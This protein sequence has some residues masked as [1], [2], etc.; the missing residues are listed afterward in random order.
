MENDLCFSNLTTMTAVVDQNISLGSKTQRSIWTRTGKNRKEIP[1]IDSNLVRTNLVEMKNNDELKLKVQECLQTC[2]TTIEYQHFM[3]ETVECL[4]KRTILNGLLDLISLRVDVFDELYE[5]MFELVKVNIIRHILP[6]DHQIVMEVK[7]LTNLNCEGF[8][9][10]SNNELNKPAPIYRS[11]ND[12][13]EEPCYEAAWSHLSLIY[14]LFVRFIRSDEFD[15][16]KAEEFIDENFV[17]NLIYLL[18]TGESRERIYLKTIIHHIYTKYVALRH[19]M[20]SQFSDIL[21]AFIYENERFNGIS[22]ILEL[23]ASIILGFILPLKEEHLK[24]LKKV[25]VPL[26]KVHS[27]SRFSTN[28]SNCMVQYVKKENDLISVILKGLVDYWPLQSST[29]EVL[30]IK[31][32]EEL[33]QLIP[34]TIFEDN[35]PLIMKIVKNGLNSSNYQ[36]TESTLY[37]WSNLTILSYFNESA[38]NVLDSVLL[39]LSKIT[40]EHWHQTIVR[41]AI[42]LLTFYVKT[43]PKIF[44]EKINKNR[45]YLIV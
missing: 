27:M 37:L 23:L 4:T 1:P 3:N 29:K 22:E 34:L 7:S 38:E 39:P 28:L 43:Y 40:R 42:A 20:R 14:D 6:I 11:D 36:V 44:Q 32:M 41:I 18:D 24:T 17:R 5:E 31:E 45:Q 2:Q 19:Y 9:D 8:N 21:L 10:A 35:I 16:D 33:I 30:F 13:D 26:H 15:V 12:F 25:L